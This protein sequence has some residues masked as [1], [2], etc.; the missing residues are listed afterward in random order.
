[1]VRAPVSRTVFEELRAR[2]PR[3]E[4]RGFRVSRRVSR[5]TC[6]PGAGDGR[7]ASDLAFDF[8]YRAEPGP[9]FAPRVV[10]EGVPDAALEAVP[11]GALDAFAFHLGLM[12]VPS[13][14]KATCSPE[15]AVLP[16]ALSAG[17]IEWWRHLL[18]EGM[19]EFFF[20]NGIDPGRPD[21]VRWVAEGDRAHAPDTRTPPPGRVLVPLAGGKDSAVTA[22]V[23]AGAGVEGGSVLL[24]P[25]RAA[26]DVSALGAWRDRVVVRR[27]IDPALLE[28]NRL[29]YL[30]GHTPFSAYLA[31][32]SVTVAALFGY[33]RVALSNERSSNE[34]NVEYLGRTVNHQY[35]KSW[36]FERRFRSY[37]GEHLAPGVEYFS[38]LRPLFELQIAGLFA[39]HPRYHRA[40][41]SCNRGQ[42]SNAW[43]GECPKCLFVFTLLSCFLEP[44]EVI[45]VFGADLFGRA[46]LYP[47]ARRLLGAEGHKPM[48]CVGTR[49]ETVVAFHLA[50]LRRASG[51]A[52]PPLLALVEDGVL[53]DEP[54]LPRRAGELLGSWNE[55]HAVPAEL[56]DA[57]RREAA[58]LAPASLAPT[59]TGSAPTEPA[60]PTASAPT[61][62]APTE[63][64]PATPAPT[65][66]APVPQ[67]R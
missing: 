66:A 44:G 31:F 49:E 1:M 52:P 43:C 33:G 54:D 47:L 16:G 55:E 51:G 29:G 28:L 12:E 56:A 7:A 40:F 34:G 67:G 2:H 61:A 13:Y 42:G 19:G 15:I 14:W 65:V 9:A 53:R 27:S 39:R 62:P 30:N 35:S 23:L 38:F 11:P 6:A 25:T 21:L 5:P 63:P 41:R 58:S 59:P 45:A 57:L 20:T 32:L 46:E 50:G 26:L 36:E 8:S 4:Y 17:Q 60:P 37:A 48:E 3:F 64:D 22:E 24:E 10:I 18:V